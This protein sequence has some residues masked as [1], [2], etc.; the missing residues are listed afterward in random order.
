MAATNTPWCKLH[1][2]LRGHPKLEDLADELDI[3]PVYAVE[4]LVYLWTWLT[5]YRPDGDMTGLTTRRIERSAGW[6]GTHGELLSALVVAGFV[7]RDGDQLRCHNWMVYAQSYKRALA[8]KSTRTKAKKAEK[9]SKKSAK[10]PKNTGETG[11]PT[12]VISVVPQQQHSDLE[13]RGEERKREERKTENQ[14]PKT[15]SRESPETPG[16]VDEKSAVALVVAHYRKAHPTRGRALRPGHRD[17]QRIQARLDE[18]FAPNDLARAIDG[19]ARCPWHREVR[20]HTVEYI[21]RN[22]GQVEDMM[23]RADIPDKPPESPSRPRITEAPSPP[24][25][26]PFEREEDEPED[27]SAY[28]PEARAAMQWGSA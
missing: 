12:S 2:N 9:R 16:D 27:A 13:R 15:V 24:Y 7:D 3:P 20:K 11:M 22:A 8:A 18:G 17:W 26:R 25:H 23:S 10:S 14:K 21:F 6:T 28:G 19:N 5:D 4:H 1:S